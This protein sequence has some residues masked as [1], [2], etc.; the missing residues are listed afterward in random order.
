MRGYSKRQ[1]R[2]S[3]KKYYDEK[4]LNNKQK[5]TMIDKLFY[6]IFI[7]S[8]LLLSLVLL[9]KYK[10]NYNIIESSDNINFLSIA[11]DIDSLFNTN[12]F[13]HGEMVVYSRE[14]YD[15]VEYENGIN[16]VVNDTFSGVNSLTDGV[17]IKITN[18][19][20]KYNVMIQSSDNFLYSYEG[21]EGI[22]VFMYQY[23]TSNQ[24]L[25]KAILT[26]DKY[27]FLLKISYEGNF[28]NYYENAE[29]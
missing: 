1:H 29:D 27:R 8:L 17:V 6:R 4:C 22:D 15:H 19:N 24:T 3:I 5:I 11:Q 12:I 7:S 2:K 10:I 21:L 23:V 9:N 20:N 16:Y 26:K 18:K 13:N 28:Y 25:G 14:S